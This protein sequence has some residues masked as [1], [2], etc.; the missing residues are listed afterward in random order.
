MDYLSGS[1]FE[2]RTQKKIK[3]VER[4]KKE[5]YKKKRKKLL[6]IKQ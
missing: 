2:L 6:V 3:S 5:H 1:E 4:G